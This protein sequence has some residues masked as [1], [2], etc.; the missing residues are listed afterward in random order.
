MEERRHYVRLSCSLKVRCKLDQEGADTFDAVGMNISERGMLMRPS[1][2]LREGQ[3][4]RMRFTLP[5]E[6][7]I[8]NARAMV[9]R[10]E[11]QDCVAVHFISVNPNV[12]ELFA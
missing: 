8:R 10:V 1:G 7:E 12:Q 6:T 9:N 3:P 2:G 4:I 11:P 5:D